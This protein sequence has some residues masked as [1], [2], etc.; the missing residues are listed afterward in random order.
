[1]NSDNPVTINGI[2][3]SLANPFDF[4]FPAIAD[5]NVGGLG[6]PALAG[7]YG[8]AD[9]TA[10]VGTRFGA[11]DGDQTT[12]GVIS[13]GPPSS[14]NRAV[15]LL[16]TTSTGYTGFGAK[17]INQTPYTLNSITLQFT[18]EV[19]RQSDT[20]KTLLFYYFI[21]P[22]ATAPLLHQLHRPPARPE[23][24]LPQGAGGCGRSRCRWHRTCQ[25]NQLGT[26]QPGDH[27]LAARGGA[28]V[29]VGDD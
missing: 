23:R 8:M 11:T 7:W 20:P 17:F 22:T 6:I 29:G 1:V 28:V 12:G 16:A 26:Y 21:D 19:W 5:G 13:F 4:A 14:S 18:G 9:P 27:Q 3:Y 15:G 24:K 10:S 2:T 25:P